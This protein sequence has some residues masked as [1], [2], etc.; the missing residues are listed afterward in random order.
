LDIHKQLADYYAI[1]KETDALYGQF[2]K[3]SGISV[4]AFWILYDMKQTPE[5]S[6]QKSICE[7]WSISKQT[8]NSA[9]KELEK[10]GFITLA[11]MENDRRTKRIELTKAGNRCTKKYIDTV[12]EAEKLTFL[13]M[14]DSEREAMIRGSK[15]YLEIFK[16]ETAGILNRSAEK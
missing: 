2:A 9:L 13:K 14:S 15:R 7:H 16:E 12:Y 4:T 6:T 3:K 10:K 5:N 11:E 8:V 1:W